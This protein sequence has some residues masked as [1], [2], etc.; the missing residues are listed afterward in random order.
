MD[1]AAAVLERFVGQL[2]QPVCHLQ[3]RVL[4]AALPSATSTTL[5]NISGSNGLTVPNTRGC[6]ESLYGFRTFAS[7]IDMLLVHL[8]PV[9]VVCRRRTVCGRNQR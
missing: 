4:C 8:G 2:I 1:G 6:G 7:T 9:I 3:R 5:A